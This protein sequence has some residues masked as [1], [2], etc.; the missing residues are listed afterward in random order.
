MSGVSRNSISNLERN[1]NNNGQAVDP[2]LSTVYNLAQALNVP[3]VA[4][5]P[6]AGREVKSIC[7]DN[8]LAI[9]IRWP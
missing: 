7:V 6:A 4:L 8:S 3:P 9:D 1:E 2:R 5:L